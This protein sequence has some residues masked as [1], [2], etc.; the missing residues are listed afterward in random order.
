MIFLVINKRYMHIHG[1]YQAMRFSHEFTNVEE[2]L[3]FIHLQEDWYDWI[4]ITKEIG[5]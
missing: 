5:C 2:A 4:V 1:I 3:K